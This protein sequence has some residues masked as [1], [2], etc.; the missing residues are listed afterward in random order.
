MI[1]RSSGVSAR[2]TSFLRSIVKYRFF[3]LAV[4]QNDAFDRAAAKQRTIFCR[5]AKL[6]TVIAATLKPIL[7]ALVHPLAASA[8][9][10][11]PSSTGLKKQPT[12]PERLKRTNTTRIS[13]FW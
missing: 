4:I 2:L 12:M 11:V 7:E 3:C 1:F 10:S 8:A 6:Q 5:G 9:W 13:R